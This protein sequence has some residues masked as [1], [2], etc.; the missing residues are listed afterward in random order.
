MYPNNAQLHGYLH[1]I[2][3]FVISLPAVRKNLWPTFVSRSTGWKP[4][5]IRIQ[6]L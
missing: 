4:H 1:L 6:G 3:A 5:Y 2:S